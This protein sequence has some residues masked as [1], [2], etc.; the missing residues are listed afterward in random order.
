M[1]G[2]P[3]SRHPAASTDG[4]PTTAP[5]WR[6]IPPWFVFGTDDRNI[7]ATLQRF[8]AERGRFAG[9][10]RDRRCL[11]RA[12]RLHL[13]ALTGDDGMQ[14]HGETGLVD[15]EAVVGHRNRPSR[16]P[17]PAARVRGRSSAGASG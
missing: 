11:A 8:T 12:L 9:D 7:P 14:D 1:A 2:H 15:P 5:A 4:L 16:V 6:T 17:V 10:P 13:E 3:A